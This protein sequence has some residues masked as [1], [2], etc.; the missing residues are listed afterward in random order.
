LLDPFLALPRRALSLHLNDKLSRRGQSHASDAHP[1]V[2]ILRLAPRAR[3]SLVYVRLVA[4]RKIGADFGSARSLQICAA[5][6]SPP[7]IHHAYACERSASQSALKFS[8]LQLRYVQS[9]WPLAVS[10]SQVDLA[11]LGPTVRTTMSIRSATRTPPIGLLSWNP[12]SPLP[13]MYW[14]LTD[15]RSHRSPVTLHARAGSTAIPPLNIS[16]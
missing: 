9:R 8:R 15:T 2:V 1:P 13:V 16:L 14:T 4:N 5:R 12:Q 6:R 11:R 10:F 3:L 7:H